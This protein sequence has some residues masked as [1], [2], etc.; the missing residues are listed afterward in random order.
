MKLNNEIY[1]LIYIIVVR[2]QLRASKGI[3]DLILTLTYIDWIPIVEI[4]RLIK[5]NLSKKEK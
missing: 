5:I 3:T 1:P 2:V 4:R